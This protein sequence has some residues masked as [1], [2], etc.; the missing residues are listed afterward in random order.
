MLYP[1]SMSL[2]TYRKF[3]PLLLKMLLRWPIGGEQARG[4]ASGYHPRQSPKSE[5][6]FSLN[7]FALGLSCSSKKIFWLIQ[8][9]AKDHSKSFTHVRSLEMGTKG[10]EADLRLSTAT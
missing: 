9:S 5:W 3:Q 2:C 6:A 7:P 4:Q 8:D 10:M 1:G